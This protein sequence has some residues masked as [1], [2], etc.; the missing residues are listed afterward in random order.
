MDEIQQLKN[1][2]AEIKKR[3]A[4]VELDKTW[5]T[6]WARKLLIAVFTYIVIVIF[7]YFADLQKP[8][9]NAIVPTIGFILST[10]SVPL[11]KKFWMKWR[12]KRDNRDDLMK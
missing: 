8:F 1:E 6:S 4:R 5:E 3:N 2:I 11:F 9:V 10:F 7:F 12:S